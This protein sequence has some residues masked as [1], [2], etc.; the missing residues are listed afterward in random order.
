MTIAQMAPVVTRKSLE[1]TYRYGGGVI[2]ILLSAADTGGQFSAWESVQKPGNEP[3]LHVHHNADETFLVM[4]GT[5]RF[6]VGEE[7][8][9]APAGSVV[10]APRGIPHTFRIKSEFARAITVCTPGGFEEWFRTLGTPAENFDLPAQVE[11]FSPEELPR[12]LELGR[13]LQTELI[14]PV[15]F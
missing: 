3:P 2:S 11:P 10:F 1:N 9:D 6:M 5:M 15:E 13:K 4:E 14:R 12:M 7:V 8:V